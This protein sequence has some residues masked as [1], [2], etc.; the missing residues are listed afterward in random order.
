[1][2]DIF[3]SGLKDW[4]PAIELALILAIVAGVAVMVRNVLKKLHPIVD[5]L[6]AQAAKT[7]GGLDDVVAKGLNL[8]LGA[9]EGAVDV[10]EKVA[11]DSLRGGLTRVNPPAPGPKR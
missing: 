4:L 6:V 2:T 8:L 9:A 1:M 10:A 11:G 7:P 3:T 5:S